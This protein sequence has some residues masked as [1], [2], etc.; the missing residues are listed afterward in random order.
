M[1]L[2]APVDYLPELN[3]ESSSVGRAR[4]VKFNLLGYLQSGRGKLRQVQ[5]TQY[6]MSA[7]PLI[8]SGSL[9]QS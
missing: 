3:S 9:I 7:A 8:L 1:K 2:N 5:L 4:W 6:P